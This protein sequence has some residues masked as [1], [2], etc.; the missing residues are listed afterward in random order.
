MINLLRAEDDDDDDDQQDFLKQDIHRNDNPVATLNQT[1]RLLLEIRTSSRIE[2]RTFLPVAMPNVTSPID[3]SQFDAG[4]GHDSSRNSF[5]PFK[6]LQELHRLPKIV[7]EAGTPDSQ[8][9]TERF[10]A[11]VGSGVHVRIREPLPYWKEIPRA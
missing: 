2:N 4:C 9:S 7:T 1:H 5:N 3:E 6:R 11:Y 10:P 8:R